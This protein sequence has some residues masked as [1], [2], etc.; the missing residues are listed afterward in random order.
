VGKK[1]KHSILE[2]PNGLI[3]EVKTK[4]KQKLKKS[5]CEKYLRKNKCCKSCPINWA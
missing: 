3:L 1:Q 2:Q 4:K 5:C